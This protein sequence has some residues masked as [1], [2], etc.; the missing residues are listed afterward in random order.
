[1]GSL[2]T[3]YHKLH[4]ILILS[5]YIN[6]HVQEGGMNGYLVRNNKHHLFNNSI[7]L[8]LVIKQTR[9][10]SS[11]KAAKKEGKLV[12]SEWD[13]SIVAGLFFKQYKIEKEPKTG[14]FLLT[15]NHLL[16]KL[17]S[18]NNYIGD[19]VKHNHSNCVYNSSR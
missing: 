4:R 1:M 15:R 11:Q 19:R 8:Y 16:V 9:I 3:L 5:I 13:C 14:S 12:S 18:L 6:I 7:I 2:F 10:L 17:R